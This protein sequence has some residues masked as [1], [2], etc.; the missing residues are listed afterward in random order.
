MLDAFNDTTKVTKSHIPAA[1]APAKIDVHNG[2]NNV[3]TN[4][5]FVARL[6]HG[7]TTRLKGFSPLKEEVDGQNES[8]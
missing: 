7:R 5:S 4:D 2:Q 6:K 1:N 3:P 8:S